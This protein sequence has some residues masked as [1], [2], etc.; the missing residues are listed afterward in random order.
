MGSMDGFQG[1]RQDRIISNIMH[2]RSF[3]LCYLLESLIIL[4]VSH[5][6]TRPS[7]IN[8]YIN[9]IINIARKLFM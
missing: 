5:I 8:I 6:C 4:C 3:I 7:N 1:V 9:Y 2:K